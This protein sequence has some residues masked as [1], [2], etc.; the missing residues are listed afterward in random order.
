MR[1]SSVPA[2]YASAAETGEVCPKGMATLPQLRRT[3]WD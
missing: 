1:D 3:T 2:A